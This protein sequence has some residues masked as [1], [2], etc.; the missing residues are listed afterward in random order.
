MSSINDYIDELF[1]AL[2][3]KRPYTTYNRDMT[4]AWII[5]HA[6]FSCAKDRVRLLSNKLD[7]KLYARNDI[8]RAIESFLNR[9][10]VLD[11]LVESDIEEGHPIR[12]VEKENAEKIY[13]TKVRDDLTGS[14]ASN[15]IVADNFGYRF[16]YNKES[17][18]AFASFYPEDEK[19][20][21]YI[22]NL[23]QWFDELKQV[24]GE[25]RQQ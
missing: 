6:V 1:K 11:I 5:T 3:K 8:I 13:I 25:M 15:F 12:N 10:G 4:H 18:N 7:P 21:E 22:G 16:E 24:S 9:G 23:S 17:H 20:K 2:E 14:L 19:E